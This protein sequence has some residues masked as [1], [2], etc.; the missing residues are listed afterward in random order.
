MEE[1]QQRGVPVD[2]A[3]MPEWARPKFSPPQLQLSVGLQWILLVYL[4]TGLEASRINVAARLYVHT[5]GKDKK[6]S[7]PSHESLAHDCSLSVQ[8]VSDSIADLEEQGWILVDRRN[9]HFNIYWLAWPVTD[10]L[11]RSDEPARCGRPTK[12]GACTR[13]AGWGTDHR[14]EGPCKLHPFEP[15]PLEFN[16]GP[17]DEAEPASTPTVGVLDDGRDEDTEP[18]STPTIGIFNS[19]HWSPQPQ[20]LERRTPTVGGEYVSTF[21]STSL[22]SSPPVAA[23][24]SP[25]VRRAKPATPAANQPGFAGR[26]LVT[27]IPRY[28]NAP[29][30]AR[31]H[32]AAMAEAALGANFGRDAILHY[33]QLVIHEA[34]Y[35]E[36][37]HLPEFRAALAR[38]GRDALLLTACPRCAADPRDGLC[39]IDPA[40]AG[41][42]WTEED[43]AALE[44]ALDRLGPTEDEL[45]ASHLD[46]G[47]CP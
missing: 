22:S 41:R 31:R 47:A 18:P 25:T 1:E 7:N 46:A 32:L 33:A 38:L 43:Q 23:V 44:R 45:A 8:T 27:A 5:V 11:A 4:S 24:G 3:D 14:G 36:H 42:S 34:A 16:N 21:L 19:N 6:T 29:G 37:Q 13:R 17:P 2:Q 9:N 40:K 28:R 10:V 30:W 15:Q 39:C 12:K 26:S 35:K 20:P